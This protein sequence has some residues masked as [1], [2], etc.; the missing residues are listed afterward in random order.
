MKKNKS[1]IIV[2]VTLIII[3]FVGS[4]SSLFFAVQSVLGDINHNSQSPKMQVQELYETKEN[5]ETINITDLKQGEFSGDYTI[6]VKRST[7]SKIRIK[8]GAGILSD[9]KLNFTG[10]KD[11]SELLIERENNFIFLNKYDDTKS[12]VQAQYNNIVNALG[13]SNKKEIIE[14]H[15]F[16]PIKLKINATYCPEIIV[17]DESLVKDEISF[18][19]KY[20]YSCIKGIKDLKVLNLELEEYQYVNVDNINNVKRLNLKGDYL[21][22]VYNNNYDILPSEIYVQGGEYLDLTIA[23]EN[24]KMKSDIAT[25]ELYYSNDI[26]SDKFVLKESKKNNIKSM[27]YNGDGREVYFNISADTVSINNME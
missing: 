7:D 19:G 16:K 5:I 8:K 18:K 6:V 11:N 22:V 25:N 3:G 17:E 27:N 23:L 21:N 9:S 24:F 1:I 20:F 10:E 2:G 13:N 12:Y 14:I 26:V 15:T 4:I